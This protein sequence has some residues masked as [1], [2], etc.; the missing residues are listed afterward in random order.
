V[1]SFPIN[2]LTCHRVRYC[3]SGM[4]AAK[5]QDTVLEDESPIDSYAPV[6]WPPGL[7]AEPGAAPNERRCDVLA[8]LG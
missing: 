5:A 2:Q 6:L 8:L 7:G 4:D 3:A 1:I